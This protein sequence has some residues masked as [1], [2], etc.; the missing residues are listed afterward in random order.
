MKDDLINNSFFLINDNTLVDESN[1]DQISFLHNIVYELTTQKDLL[2]NCENIINICNL[3]I[4]TLSIY[5]TL[6]DLQFVCYLILKRLYFTYTQF[7]PQIEDTLAMV[8]TN[9]CQFNKPVIS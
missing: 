8:M 9:L 5:E 4:N 3:V 7:R 6:F 1:R 2:V